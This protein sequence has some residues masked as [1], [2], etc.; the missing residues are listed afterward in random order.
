MALFS[1]GM[2]AHLPR[3]LPCCPVLRH[4][5]HKVASG[6][7][8]PQHLLRGGPLNPSCVAYTRQPSSHSSRSST[9]NRSRPSNRIVGLPGNLSRLASSS[10]QMAYSSLPTSRRRVEAIRRSGHLILALPLNLFT[11]A[12]RRCVL[13]A[14]CTDIGPGYKR[15]LTYTGSVQEDR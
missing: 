14:Y 13:T 2:L 15:S 8:R 6:Q 11:E 1:S 3:Y 4:T 5:W 7:R 12:H 9:G 10:V